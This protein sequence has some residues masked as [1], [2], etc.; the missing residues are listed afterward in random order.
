MAGAFAP[1]PELSEDNLSLNFHSFGRVFKAS[2][3]FMEDATHTRISVCFFVIAEIAILKY[4]KKRS[5]MY[6]YVFVKNCTL[7]NSSLIQQ[8]QLSIFINFF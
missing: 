5:S 1:V 2:I 3:R 7:V 6:I 8:S 4:S